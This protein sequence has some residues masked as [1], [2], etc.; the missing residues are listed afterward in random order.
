AFVRYMYGVISKD[1][2]APYYENIWFSYIPPEKIPNVKSFSSE[3]S[4]VIIF[5][6]LCVAPKYIQNQIIPFFTHGLIFNGGSSTHDIF[7]IVERYTNDVKG[8]SMVINS[9]LR[10]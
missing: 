8:A 1:P 3:R 9:Y 7:K 2:R 6:D 5:E 4:T 10:Q